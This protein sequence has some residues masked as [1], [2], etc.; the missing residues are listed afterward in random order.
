MRY[1]GV[2]LYWKNPNPA[3]NPGSWSNRFQVVV[4]ISTSLLVHRILCDYGPIQP[5]CHFAHL[6]TSFLYAKLEGFFGLVVASPFIDQWVG[7]AK[8]ERGGFC[9]K[10]YFDNSKGFFLTGK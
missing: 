10:L 7:G 3:T 2:P 1:C 6:R 5:T 8:P 9:S 4:E